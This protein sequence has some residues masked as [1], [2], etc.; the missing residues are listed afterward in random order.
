[1]AGKNGKVVATI[2]V[3][4][5]QFGPGE[6]LANYPRTFAE[7]WKIC[8][9]E[10]VDAVFA[11]SAE[12]LYCPDHSILIHENQLS[13]TLC[14]ASRPGHFAGVCTIVAKLFLL[15]SPQTAI[16]G[17]KDWQQLA[18]IRRLVRDLHFPVKI[19]S[20]PTVREPDGLALSSRNRYLNSEQRALA[21]RIYQALQ[22]ARHE[23][24]LRQK[25]AKILASL[26]RRLRNIPGARLDYAEIVDAETLQPP[27]STDRPLQALVAVHLGPA[28]LIDNLRLN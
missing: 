14:G 16:F 22:A 11:P 10:K 9:K 13:K 17:E 25:P 5:T 19:E 26:R 15:F 6:D 27:A 18:I 20:Y 2:F 28:R 1:L 7:D 8:R 12:E 23:F 24:A 21:P 4:P 3:N